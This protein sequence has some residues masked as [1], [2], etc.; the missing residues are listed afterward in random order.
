MSYSG[1]VSN[2]SKAYGIGKILLAMDIDSL[3]RL[4]NSGGMPMPMTKDGYYDFET[5]QKITERIRRGY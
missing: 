3:K 1:S 4:Y 2:A 5:S